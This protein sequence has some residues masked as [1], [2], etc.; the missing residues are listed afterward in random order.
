MA[1]QKNHYFLK[2]FALMLNSC[3]TGYRAGAPRQSGDDNE[4]YK[5]G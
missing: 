4:N 2:Q 5:K 1:A 3:Q